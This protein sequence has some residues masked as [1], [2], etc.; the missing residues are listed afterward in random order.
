MLAECRPDRLGNERPN[1]I[2]KV[3]TPSM[4]SARMHFNA[5]VWHESETNV[6]LSS[7]QL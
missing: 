1:H 3:D 5:E 6:R 2:R 7:I 4:G